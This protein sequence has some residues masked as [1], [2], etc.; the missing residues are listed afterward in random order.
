MIMYCGLSQI[1]YA[2]LNIPLFVAFAKIV[3]KEVATFI[4]DN[5]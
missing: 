5:N 4:S 2:E 3:A 1:R